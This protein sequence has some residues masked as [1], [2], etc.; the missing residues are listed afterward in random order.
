MTSQTRWLHWSDLCENEWP[1]SSHPLLTE[2]NLK[3]RHLVLCVKCSS[4]FSLCYVGHIYD[5]DL[6][7]CHW[8]GVVL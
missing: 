5:L 3:I 8:A 7:T 1:F 6:V 2:E 4:S